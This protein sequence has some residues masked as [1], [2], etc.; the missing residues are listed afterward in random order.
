MLKTRI[1]MLHWFL[2]AFLMGCGS[3]DGS[4]A[5]Q[6]VV[7]LDGAPLNEGMIKFQPPAG[8]DGS[9][10]TEKVTAGR[11]QA[12]LQAGKKLVFITAEEEIDNP[13]LSSSGSAK[14]PLA[15]KRIRRSIVPSRYNT[16]TELTADVNRENRK[17]KFELSGQK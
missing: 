4:I 6:G 1:V 14:N 15:P 9:S 3:P 10:V 13:D 7:T 11:F 2:I 8:E 5:V 16:K 12:N 17:L